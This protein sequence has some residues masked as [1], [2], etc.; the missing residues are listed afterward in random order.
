MITAIP[1]FRMYRNGDF[2]QYANN[3]LQL[4]TPAEATTLKID[5]QRT[6]LD[7]TVT[8]LNE[9]F[10]PQKGSELTPEIAALDASRD[11]LFYGLKAT[12]DAWAQ[13]HYDAPKKQAAKKFAN[14]IDNYGTHIGKLR[15][16][17]QT[18]TLNGIVNDI[19]TTDNLADLRLL[20]LDEWT[21]QLKNTNAAFNDGY[22]ARTEERSEQQLGVI[23]TLRD[24]AT[25]QYRALRNIFNARAVV[26][27]T[28][29]TAE[30]TTFEEIGK[31]LDALT[32]Q[33]NTAVMRFRK[34]EKEGLPATDPDPEP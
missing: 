24:K 13:Y 9:A 12:L 31:E 26:A 11:D 3:V 29:G 28:D 19:E 6:E 2:V 30:A 18:A 21:T 22:I 1:S 27:T 15:Y 25:E 34:K 10:A 14:I 7:S 8:E 5:A 4:I 17:Q 23:Q 20:G 16:Q 32:E 33:Y